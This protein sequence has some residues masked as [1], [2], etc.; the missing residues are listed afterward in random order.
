MKNKIRD[1]FSLYRKCGWDYTC[2][3]VYRRIRNGRSD[4]YEFWLKYG[5]KR[6]KE[7][8]LQYNPKV[9]VVVPVYNVKEEQLTACIES[10]RTQTYSNWELCLVDDAS[11]MKSVRD[12]L[13]KYEGKEKI[14]IKYRKKNGHISHC[15]N[16][17]IAMSEGEYIGFLDCDDILAEYAIYEIVQLLNENPKLDFIYSDED[18]I[19]EDGKTRFSPIFKPNW[20]PDTY[21][22]HNY[23]NHFS[24][25]RASITKEIGGLRTEYN[26]SQDYDFVLRFT[27]Q[28]KAD[29]IG[30]IAKVLYHWRVRPESVASGNDV[31]PY[32]FDAA[33]HATEDAI[34]RRGLQAKLEYEQYTRQYNV[35]YEIDKEYKVSIIIPVYH[36]KKECEK[37]I[38]SIR[39][40]TNYNDYEIVLIG[41]ISEEVKDMA[42]Q[43][44]CR[45]VEYVGT[46]HYAK[47]CNLGL[48][49]SGG[50]YVIFLSDRIEI[51]TSD[52][53][54]RL[55]GHCS[56]NYIG[57]VGAK[58]IY[59]NKKYIHSIG[60]EYSGNQF[61]YVRNHYLNEKNLS[62]GLNNNFLSI[63]EY[64][65]MVK[66]ENFMKY[67]LFDEEYSD[68]Y[69]VYEFC[70]RLHENGLYQVFRP[71][72]E[73]VLQ[74]L[75]DLAEKKATPVE[76]SR[77]ILEKHKNCLEKKYLYNKNYSAVMPF[78][79]TKETKVCTDIPTKMYKIEWLKDAYFEVKVAW[80][81]GLL[82]FF[83]YFCSNNKKRKLLD[84][85]WLKIKFENGREIYVQA[86]KEYLGGFNTLEYNKIGAKWAG[87]FASIPYELNRKE[88][89]D[90]Q[91]MV[92]SVLFR[93]MYGIQKKMRV[94]P[95][96]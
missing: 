12:V 64:C 22:S 88:E 48:Q 59:S 94:S 6:E 4:D 43:Y 5:E 3:A 30:H 51:Q 58:I 10:V 32:V 23:T 42:K 89:I 25:Y 28:I 38:R 84:Q 52:W 92:T 81:N 68:E 27:E 19:S 33:K 71:D 66:R 77:K 44:K 80:E 65:Y 96:L 83:G 93:K 90:V 15:T 20:S 74:E 21:L 18:L 46:Y 79:F 26:G 8:L 62:T 36:S 24:V 49:Q 40:I 9:S 53:I 39:K 2:N 50:E 75:N 11:T 76:S 31:K 34:R 73:I 63:S 35:V 78:I 16:D 67:G 57:A 41:G 70:V 86:L 45:Y 7:Q 55:V 60:V 1:L 14:K 13:E 85:I 87:F 82:Q 54:D 95:L 37:T 47:M 56:Q 91:V 29:K 69:A 72:I 61:L 17:G